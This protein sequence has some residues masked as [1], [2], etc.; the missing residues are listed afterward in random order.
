M[1]VSE[2]RADKAQALIAASSDGVLLDTNVLLLFLIGSISEDQIDK[3]K[4]LRLRDYDKEDF[5]ILK[6]ILRYNR[7][8][9]ITP[10]IATETWDLGENALSGHYLQAF[11]DLFSAFL[12]GAR[13]TWIPVERLLGESYFFRLGIADSGAARI[14]RRRPIVV[15]DDGKL[16]REL[17]AQRKKVVNFTNLRNLL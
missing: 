16:A 11:K 10:H 8:F 17:E 9:V 12:L 2:S 13:E 6:Y 4:H 14:K 3:S 5:D 15:T 7:G 1:P